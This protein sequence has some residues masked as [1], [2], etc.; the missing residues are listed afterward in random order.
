MLRQLREESILLVLPGIYAIGLVLAGQV[1]KRPVLA[2]AL[3]LYLLISL[4]WVLHRRCYLLAAWL[5]VIGCLAVDLLV[6]TYGQIGQALYLLVFPA[7]LATLLIGTSAGVAT[8]SACTILLVA[9]AT[10]LPPDAALRTTTIMGIWG[11]V[12]LI[13]LTLR[14]LITS[15]EW[16][17]SAYKHSRTLLEQ[18]RDYQVQLKQTLADLADANLQLT[19]LNQLTQALRHAAEDA[20][21]AKEQFVANVSHELRTPLN[22]IIGFSEMILQAPETYGRAIPSALLAD[23][24]VI[25]RNSQHLSS[26]IDDVLDLSQIE[27]GKMALT[28]ERVTLR[29]IVEAAVIAVRPL[30]ESKGLYLRTDI[31]DDLPAIFCDRTRIREVLLNLLSNAGRFTEHGGVHVCAVRDGSAVVVSVSDTGPGIAPEDRNKLFQP[32]QQVDGS[33]RRRYGGSGLGL[34]ISKSFVDLHNGTMWLESEV[35]R[36]TTIFFR[37]PIDPPVPIGGGVSRWFNPYGGYEERTH[38]PMLPPATVC[39]RLVVLETGDSLQRLL[40]R[41]LDNVEI[42][43]VEGIEEALQELTRVPAQALLVNTLS[44]SEALSRLSASPALTHGIP[45]IVCAVPGT[46]EAAGALG[47]ADYLVKPISREAL[48]ATLDRLELRGRTLLIVDDEPEALRLFRRMV[49]SAGRDYRVLRATNGQE[50]LSILREEHPDAMLLDL[51]MP[52]MD[53]FQLLAAKAEDPALREIPVVV[54]SARDPTGHPIVSNALAVTRRDGLS[55]PQLVACIEA[56]TRILSTTGQVG[57]PMLLR[58]PLA[59]QACG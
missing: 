12:G 15:L 24:T 32:F 16:S 56:I 45:A 9:L 30:F 37:L 59:P 34:S 40:S 54:I 8:A 23:L 21:T 39:T 11:T 20:R 14:P 28:R 53:G 55:M 51:V 49:A 25:L 58:E 17:W 41:Y 2:P 42:V 22:M 43:P 1:D 46:H 31:Q 44:V 4:V 10:R 38:V 48:L 13:W 7:G 57:D 5:L 33:V 6:A 50:A 36:G 18:S 19:R 29:E 27:A 35:G 26:L 52:Q 3:C 47:V